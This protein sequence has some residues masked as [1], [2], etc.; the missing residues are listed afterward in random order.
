MEAKKFSKTISRGRFY[1]IKT[2][3][4]L[5]DNHI[6]A[7]SKIANLLPLLDLLRTH[8]QQYG[9]FHQL[10]RIDKSM[11]PYRG[12]QSEKIMHKAKASQVWL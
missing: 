2:Y 4:H 9:T 11:V 3:F 7:Q 1:N 8:R 10:L 6:L 12:L 5:A